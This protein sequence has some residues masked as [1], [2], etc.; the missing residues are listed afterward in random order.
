MLAALVVVAAG[1]VAVA[2]ILNPGMLDDPNA[3]V[4]VALLVAVFGVYGAAAA[5]ALVHAGSPQQVAGCAFGVGAGLLWLGEI[6]TQAPAGLSPGLERTVPA[7]CVVLAVLTTVEAGVV[8][9]WVARTRAAAVSTGVWAGL[10]SGVVMVI[11]MVAIQT[12][13]VGLLGARGDYQR[14]LASSG[15]SDMATYLAADAVAASTTHMIINLGLGLLG[16]ALGLISVAA[17]TQSPFA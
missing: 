8:G 15:M 6:W 16:A 10:V 14:E 13:N 12:S 5:R 17:S 9:G 4:W 11:G 1:S 3:G 7:V 2:I